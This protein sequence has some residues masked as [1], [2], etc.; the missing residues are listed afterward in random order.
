[1]WLTGAVSAVCDGCF[2]FDI[3]HLPAIRGV[4]II[5]IKHVFIISRVLYNIIT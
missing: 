2:R 1:M 4:S 3:Y 5:S